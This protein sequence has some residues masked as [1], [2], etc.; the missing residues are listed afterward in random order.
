MASCNAR[1]T[2]IYSDFILIIAGLQGMEL[3]VF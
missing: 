2:G 3:N 1:K